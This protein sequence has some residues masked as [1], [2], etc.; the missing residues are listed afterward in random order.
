MQNKT[1]IQIGTQKMHQSDM[2]DPQRRR[3]PAHGANS[4]RHGTNAVGA[5]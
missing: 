5:P 1:S 3:W 2:S 4:L